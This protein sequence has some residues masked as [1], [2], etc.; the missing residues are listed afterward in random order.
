MPIHLGQ[1]LEPERFR[2]RN[3]HEARTE[4]NGLESS[5]LDLLV[6][7]FS[8]HE[9]IPRQLGGGDK[10]SQVRV[11]TANGCLPCSLLMV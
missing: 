7:L 6:N 2:G 1:M 8:A 9:P 3:S 5:R 4:A 10:R 11:E